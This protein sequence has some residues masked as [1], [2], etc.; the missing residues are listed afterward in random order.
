MHIPFW[1]E[2]IFQILLMAYIVTSPF[3]FMW[4]HKVVLKEE[5]NDD[6]ADRVTLRLY[7]FS[8]IGAMTISYIMQ[9]CDKLCK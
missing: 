5:W 4:F 1:L 2:M 8:N 9:E 7:I 3:I 6:W